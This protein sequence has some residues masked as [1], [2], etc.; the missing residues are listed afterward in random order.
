VGLLITKVLRFALALARALVMC[1]GNA[2][3][4]DAVVKIGG[5]IF[6]R[7]DAKNIQ[8]VSYVKGQRIA[9]VGLYSLGGFLAAADI[10]RHQQ[11]DLL[12]SDMC[13]LAFTGTPHSKVVQEVMAGSADVGIVRTGVP[14]Q[15][16]E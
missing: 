6:T 12:A 5:V 15:M 3:A 10:F 14:E 11:I 1:I 4:A 16:A 13:S 8:Q 2:S 9:A 7:V